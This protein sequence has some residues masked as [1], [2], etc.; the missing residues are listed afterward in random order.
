MSVIKERQNKEFDIKQDARINNKRLECQ[1]PYLDKR[2]EPNYEY[3]T[4]P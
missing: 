4:I 3:G 1:L 2:E